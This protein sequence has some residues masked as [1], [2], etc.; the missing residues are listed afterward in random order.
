MYK[1]HP[2]V[3]T[4]KCVNLPC[5]FYTPRVSQFVF[6]LYLLREIHFLLILFHMC[7]YN[8]LDTYEGLISFW[9]GLTIIMHVMYL[10]A[11]SH[12]EG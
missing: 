11:I 2:L 12:S 5:P 4:I 9:K 1:L 6:G 7:I 8:A 10:A 3:P